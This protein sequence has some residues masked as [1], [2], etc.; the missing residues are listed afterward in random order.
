MKILKNINLE[1]RIFGRLLVLNLKK[2]I[3]GFICWEC[4]CDCGKKIFVRNYS[5]LNGNTKSC[6]C[7]QKDITIKN[8]SKK[9]T[10]GISN[11]KF[12]YAY[13]DL[14]RRCYNI[15][16]KSYKD[17]GG[18]GI[19][20]CEQWK[21]SFENFKNDM[22]ESYLKHVKE[23]GKKQT[24]IDRINTNGNYCKENCRWTTYKEQGR[25][26]RNNHLIS[27]KNKTKSM[28]E[29][30]EQYNLSVYSLYQ[31]LKANWSLEKA[32]TTPILNNIKK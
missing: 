25:N 30:A 1:G 15:K 19:N 21:N 31:R 18:R 12:Y 22:Y 5:L 23:F 7:L 16:H 17:Y 20:V 24:T 13:F 26:K 28:T 9:V 10:H 8:N 3:K 6:N 32:L 2:E 29:W 4:K 14:L 27:Y 11:T